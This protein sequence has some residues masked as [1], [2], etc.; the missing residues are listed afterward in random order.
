M[1]RILITGV[2]GF[3]GGDVLYGLTQSLA[4]S[5]ITALVRNQGQAAAVTGR[6]PTVTPL[7]GDL[8]SSAEIQ[9][10]ASEAD[11]VLHLASSSHVPSAK[12]IADGLLKS[13]RENP[14]WIQIAGAS[15]LAGG[16]I[17]SKA[18]GQPGSKIYNDLP[19]VSEI[20]DILAASPKRT[21]DH[22]V[23]D[24]PSSNPRART[25]IVY[26]PLIYGKGRGP[27]NQRSIQIPDLAKAALQ[28]GRCPHV[29][30]G[31]NTWNTIHI[32]DL[33]S[34]F[35]R[36]A[37]ASSRG[38]NPLLWNE[39]GVYFAESGK[40]S[41]GDIA[42]K[43]STFAHSRGFIK[44]PEVVEMDSETA[45][46]LTPHGSVIWG[47]NAQYQA[48]RARELL[49]WLPQA[50]GIEEEIPRAVL[51]EALMHHPRPAEKLV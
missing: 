46:R 16:E 12:A 32:A 39:N 41:F 3:I 40:I 50:H 35:V 45:D 1:S 43:I 8:D 20:H 13:E 14:T 26:G 18:F 2:T 27:V 21:V 30:R 37:V 23:R 47:T 44:S 15:F 31:L 48:I 25:A 36:L 22:L 42:K 7:I 28:H 17:Q 38:S 11:V 4:S 19:G 10:A 51:A 5:R 49:G 6:F 24:L 33:T 29:G 34:L 9:Q